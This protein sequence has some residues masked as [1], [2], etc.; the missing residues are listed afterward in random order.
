MMKAIVHKLF[1][2]LQAVLNHNLSQTSR[3]NDVK[4]HL[5]GINQI[6]SR[7]HSKVVMMYVSDGDT[8]F[9]MFHYVYNCPISQRFSS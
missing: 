5:L 1:D 7:V 9:G 3:I 6:A 8:S 4:P 2:I